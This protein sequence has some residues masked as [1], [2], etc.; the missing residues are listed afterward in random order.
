M[1]QHFIQAA[2]AAFLLGAMPAAH[3]IPTLSLQV[4]A[5]PAYVCA[6]GSACDTLASV[7]GIVAISQTLGDFYVN[8]TT[9]A[10]KPLLIGG[11][12]LMDLASFNIQV[13]GGA[14]TLVIGFSDTDFDIYGGQFG[15]QF[16]GALSGQGASIEHAAYY[17]AGN[18]LFGQT[19]LIGQ[20][21]YG[22]GAFSGSASNG[23][24]PEAPYSVTEILTLRTAGG[25]L[26]TLASGDFEVNVPEPATLALLG[27]G[28]LGFSV[29]R[30]RVAR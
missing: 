15:M 17:D 22:E 9:G 16:G 27:L 8:L 21:A 28:L 11:N 18:T 20:F 25:W 13:G 24:S 1:K 23:W 14:H 5:G 2:A 19:T 6:D 26:P 3:A 4:D 29:A 30:R 12:P 7:A 10:S